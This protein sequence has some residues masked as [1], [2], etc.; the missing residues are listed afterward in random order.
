MKA[1]HRAVEVRRAGPSRSRVLGVWVGSSSTLSSAAGNPIAERLQRSGPHGTSCFLFLL[2]LVITALTG[3]ASVPPSKEHPQIA[4]EFDNLQ[5][6]RYALVEERGAEVT[7][8]V[9]RQAMS[10]ARDRYDTEVY[11]SVSSRVRAGY[12]P[13]ESQAFM[14]RSSFAAS[15]GGPR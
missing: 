4:C 15:Q 14:G 12:C 11:V 3:C 5:R 1:D 6:F 10:A 13:D 7:K 9:P 2:L 8:W